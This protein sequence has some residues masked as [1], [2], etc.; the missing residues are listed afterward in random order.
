MEENGVEN[1]EKFVKKLV[2]VSSDDTPA[3]IRIITIKRGEKEMY[4]SVTKI[5]Q[6]TIRN[7]VITSIHVDVGRKEKRIYYSH[8]EEQM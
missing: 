6:N 8:F 7:I 5:E 3:I 4:L 1:I 2:N